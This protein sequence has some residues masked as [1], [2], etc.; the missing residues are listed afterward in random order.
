MSN[1]PR[2]KIAGCAGQH[3]VRYGTAADQKYLIGDFIDTYDQLVL[4]GNMLAHTPSALSMFISQKVKKPFIIDPQTHAFAHGVEFLLSDSKSSLG[5][6]KKSWRKLIEQYGAVVSSALCGDPPRP[7][8]PDD[9]NNQKVQYTFAEAVLQF[10]YSSITRELLDGE[11]AEYVKFLLRKTG[12]N[13]A[14]I[15]PEAVI[16]PYFYINGPEAERWLDLNSDFIKVSRQVSTSKKWNIP[17]AAQLVMP[18]E[19][20][21]DKSL[22]SK[23][24]TKYGTT[25]PDLLL[26]WIDDFSEHDVSEQF[27]ANYLD[28]L[29]KLQEEGIQVVVLFGGFFSVAIMR[30]SKSIHNLVGVCHGL[31]YGERRPVVPL[32]GGT[33]VA[34]FYSKNLHHR[35]PPRAALREMQALLAL[36]NTDAFY[37]KICNCPQCKNIIKSD[38]GKEIDAYFETKE[39]SFWSGRKYMTRDFPTADASDNCTCHYMWCKNW[40][41]REL[42]ISLDNLKSELSSFYETHWSR[43]GVEYAGH[44]KRWSLV[45]R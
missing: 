23:I 26:L 25:K 8:I 4:N 44:P 20:L 12:T 41:Y 43:L 11:D 22:I 30:F 18:P 27:L 10:Q 17:V 28:F 24:V 7:L 34:K 35:L 42:E 16:A 38:P 40:E 39:V 31:E 14:H 32:G 2:T 36:E 5:Q 3:W 6:I 29:S 15:A 13:V 33:P 1:L 19:F 21:L 37:E 9:F 45:L